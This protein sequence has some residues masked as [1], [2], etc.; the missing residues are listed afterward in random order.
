[1]LYTSSEKEVVRSIKESACY[2]AFDPNKEE[3]LIENEKTN[4]TASTKYKLPDGNVIEVVLPLFAVLLSDILVHVPR[5][6]V[7]DSELLKS[8]FH[9]G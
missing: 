7:R 1:V 8:C 3:E 2:V 9:H 6:V 4:K 5:L